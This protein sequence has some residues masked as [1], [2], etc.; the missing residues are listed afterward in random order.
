MKMEYFDQ[1]T[2]DGDDALLKEAKNK[3]R[4]QIRVYW[5]VLSYQQTPTGKS[6]CA[7]C[8]GPRDRCKGSP[9]D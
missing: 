4:Y 5:E 1:D 9:N 7:G 2:A 3:G 8:N 6:P